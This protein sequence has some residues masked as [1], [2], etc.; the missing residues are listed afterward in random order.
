MKQLSHQMAY[1]TL[2][3]FAGRRSITVAAAGAARNIVT[4]AKTVASW[5]SSKQK[6]NF[7]TTRNVRVHRR[8]P[9]FL[10]ASNDVRKRRVD[11]VRRCWRGRCRWRRRR[12]RTSRRTRWSEACSRLWWRPRTR[13]RCKGRKNV[14]GRS[15]RKGRAKVVPE[16]QRFTT[17]FDRERERILFRKKNFSSL[18]F[19]K[20]KDIFHFKLKKSNSLLILINSKWRVTQD[21]RR[22]R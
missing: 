18:Y 6:K 20:K 1:F 4:S 2:G 13:R 22:R 10:W 15:K 9:N 12:S 11:I 17:W 14:E 21:V 7:R 8:K 19:C 16:Q 3:H 5:S